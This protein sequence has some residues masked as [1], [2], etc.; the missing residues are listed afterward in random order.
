MT[1][2]PSADGVIRARSDVERL[3]AYSAPLEGR[4]GML[5]LD[6]NENTIGPSP[7]VVEALRAIPAE[8][9]AVYPEYNGLREAV[10]ANLAALPA[11]LAHDLAPACVGVFN[12][13]DGAIHAVLQAYGGQVTPCSPPAPRSGTTPHAPACRGWRL[14]RCRIRCL[15]MASRT[16]R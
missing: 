5:R 12:G 9:L 2:P 3:K 6:F 10:V 11:G 15:D 8:Q 4:R 13:V 14:R 1:Q 7:K 16:K